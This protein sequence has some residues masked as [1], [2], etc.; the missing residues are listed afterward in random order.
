MVPHVR[1]DTLPLQV[2]VQGRQVSDHLHS[3]N[4]CGPELGRKHAG[5]EAVETL[6][7]IYLVLV[8]DC[9]GPHQI[10]I[11]K[12]RSYYAREGPPDQV[13][14]RAPTD[15][16]CIAHM[17]QQ[18]LSVGY[19]LR[20]VQLP[21]KSAVKVDAQVFRVT[22]VLDGH[23]ADRDLLGRWL[24]VFVLG[25]EHRHG[26]PGAEDHSMSSPPRD[27]FVECPLHQGD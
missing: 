17:E 7:L 9:M 21:G 25:E 24:K 15:P 3:R 16:K 19:L 5:D 26:F 14:P 10:T 12:G 6:E 23:P 8:P 22:R 18:S 13:G 1:L 11:G 4:L 2:D 27:G 20:E